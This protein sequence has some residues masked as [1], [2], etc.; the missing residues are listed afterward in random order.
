[1]K[2]LSLFLMLALLVGCPKEKQPTAPDPAATMTWFAIFIADQEGATPPATV[3]VEATAGGGSLLFVEAPALLVDKPPEGWRRW[4]RIGDATA[5]AR[6]G[7]P[8]WL[9]A[10]AAEGA[11]SSAV[12]LELTA[13]AAAEPDIRT[14]LQSSGVRVNTIAGNIVTA[15]VPRG[16]WGALLKLSQLVSVEPADVVGKKAP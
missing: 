16:A 11:E 13:A 8:G 7:N 10:A 14:T 3:Q 4:T 6:L 12:Y 15:S 5:R 9:L 2:S 1:M